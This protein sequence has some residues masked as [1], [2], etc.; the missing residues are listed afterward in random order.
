[1]KNHRYAGMDLR[2]KNH[3]VRV[4]G[5]DGQVQE[6]ARVVNTAEAITRYFGSKPRNMVVAMEAG[7]HSGWIC[8]LLKAWGFG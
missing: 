7:T 8:R 1:M 3:E 2:D 4:I 6:R 5:A